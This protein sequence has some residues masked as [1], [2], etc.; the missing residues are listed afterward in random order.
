MTE[1]LADY[2]SEKRRDVSEDSETDREPLFTTQ[3]GRITK[4]TIRRN[5]YGITRP[6][7]YGDGCPHGRDPDDCEAAVMKNDA[8][9]CPS[10]VSGHPIRRGSITHHLRSDTPKAILSDR[11][12]VSQDVLDEHYIEMTEEEKMEQRREYLDNI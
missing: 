2:V 8:A 7:V 9:G 6:C 1:V 11:A 4:G 5:F 10:T 12:N 3:H